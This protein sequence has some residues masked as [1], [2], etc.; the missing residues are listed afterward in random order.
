MTLFVSAHKRV[1]AKVQEVAGKMSLDGKILLLW[2]LVKLNKFIFLD[3]L[4]LQDFPPNALPDVVVEVAETPIEVKTPMEV[5]T[6]IDSQFQTF[7][8]TAKASSELLEHFSKF[9]NG[10]YGC[11]IDKLF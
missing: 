4:P 3:L 5:E 11:S 8:L 6:P 9:A 2:L 10:F 1:S 7:K